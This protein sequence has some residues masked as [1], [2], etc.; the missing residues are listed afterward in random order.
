MGLKQ[1]C[2]QGE[3]STRPPKSHSLLT[4]TLFPSLLFPGFS[5]N[6]GQSPG[7]VTSVKCNE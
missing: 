1:V 4:H 3:E 2:S 5:V 7:P 6:A